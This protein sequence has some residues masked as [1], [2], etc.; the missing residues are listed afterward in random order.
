MMFSMTYI[1]PAWAENIQ[2]KAK[3]TVPDGFINIDTEELPL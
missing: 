1:F 3:Q 2:C